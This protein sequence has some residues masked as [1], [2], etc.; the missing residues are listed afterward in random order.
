ME[1]LGKC[2]S[3]SYVEDEVER[4]K[5]QALEAI[6]AEQAGKQQKSRFGKGKK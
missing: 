5:K 3:A 4:R 1:K 6:E 2:D